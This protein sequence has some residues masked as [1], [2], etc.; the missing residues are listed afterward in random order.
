MVQCFE[1]YYNVHL[2]LYYGFDNVMIPI[3]LADI[4]I[5]FNTCYV[6]NGI[7]IYDR[8]LIATKYVRSIHFWVDLTCFIISVL[9]VAFNSQDHYQTAF[10]FIVF[11]K[12]IKMYSFDQNIKKYGLKSFNSLLIYEI[13]KNIVF[14]SLICFTLGAF[15][16]LIDYNLYQNMTYPMSGPNS[17]PYWII[18]S[19]SYSMIIDQNLWVKV[20]YCYYYTIVLLSG[21]AYGDLVP[22]NPVETLYTT[23]LL[24]FPLVIYS[25]VFNAIYS[26]ISKK[27]ERNKLIRKYQ[28]IST[29]YLKNLKVKKTL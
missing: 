9:Q 11:I 20:T 25:Y 29:R 2:I 22:Q 3:M 10:N 6:K 23:L 28:F 13:I 7:V 12:V 1:S 24:F 17:N 26:I 16:Y 15:F 18:G 4:L 21:V 14:L 27:R 5:T 19:S 8:R